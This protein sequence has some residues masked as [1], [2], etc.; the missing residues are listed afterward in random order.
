MERLLATRS[1]Q[2]LELLSAETRRALKERGGPRQTLVRRAQP[3]PS[4]FCRAASTRSARTR[5]TGSSRCCCPSRT[6]RSICRRCLRRLLEQ[7][8]SARLEIVAIDSGSSDDTPRRPGRLRG[9]GARDRAVGLRSWPYSQ[10][11]CRACARRRAG[12]PD[13][14]RPSRRRR[15]AGAAHR[16]AGRRP[17]RGRRV[18][19]AAPPPGRRPPHAPGRRARPLRAVSAAS[20]SRSTIW[21]AYEHMSGGG[22]PAIPELP[23]RQRRDPSRR[24]PSHPVP[25]SPRRSARTCC[26][27]ARWSSPAGRSCTSRPRL[28]STLTPTRSTSCSAATSTTESRTATSSTG[29]PRGTRSLR[30]SG[31]IVDGRLD[32]SARRTRAG[33]PG[34]RALAARVGAAASR[35][36]RRSMGW[37]QLRDASRRHRRAFS[38]TSRRRVSTPRRA[39]ERRLSGPIGMRL[40]LVTHRYPPFGVTGVER[41][42]EQTAEKLTAA[43]RR[44]HCPD[45]AANRRRRL[46]R[47]SSGASIGASMSW[48][49]AGG[50]PLHGRFPK[51]APALE[52]LFERTLL[53]VQPDIVLMSHLIDHS[54]GYVSIAR[55]WNVPVVLE[56]HDYYLACEQARLQRRSGDL[57]HG[58][59]GGSACAT[60]CF[61]EQAKSVARWALRT[62][63][64]RRAARPGG[65]SR[66]P[67]SFRRRAISADA[68]GSDLP[69]AARHRQRRGCDGPCQHVKS[70]RT[71]RSRRLCRGSRRA[72]GRAR[73]R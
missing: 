54:P 14:A 13:A 44:G 5:A 37:H 21:P 26:G 8:I 56:L 16:G 34:A 15:V 72:Q 19:P 4:L 59:E 60:H 11:A 63:M 31:P 10:P 17:A 1:E 49:I 51:L 70:G 71:A 28:R 41:V 61:P 45:Q 3:T 27:L 35:S 66:R 55:R 65:R 23:H 62:H 32:V 39:H 68:F 57:C 12:V 24:A 53:D 20:T 38:Q 9:T 36:D 6:G 29:R 18:Q 22:A 69:T 67:V 73:S 50:G 30:T 47:D 42:A 43:R 52:R 46:P 33:R 64:F 2:V 58:P 40:L 7:S 25:L 48:M